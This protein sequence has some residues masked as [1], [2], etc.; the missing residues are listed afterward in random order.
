MTRTE[1]LLAELI[2]LPSVNP[3]FVPKSVARTRGPVAQASRLPPSVDGC[4]R[5]A[6]ATSTNSARRM[7]RIFSPPSPRAP[8]SKS[9]SKKFCPDVP[10]S[11]RDCCRRIKSARPSCSRRT[12]T[13]S[14]PTIRN[15]F[16]AG[17]TAG[18]TDAARATQKVPSPPCSPRFA[19]WRMQNRV[20]WKPKLF[21]P[22]WWTRKT[23][24]PV[25]A[26]W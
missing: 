16:R 11:S 23:R 1:K 24:R 5:D 26:H 9:N 21:L 7:W 19:N 20:R 3:A 4:R 15:S 6:C 13:P 25:R 12:S 2:A 10:I 22:V 8:D 14:T 17:K 18:F